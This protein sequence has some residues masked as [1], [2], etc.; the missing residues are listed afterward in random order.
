M[1]LSPEALEQQEKEALQKWAS[2]RY[3]QLAVD[4]SST[5]DDAD[6]ADIATHYPSGDPFSW[7][8]F[9]K[10]IFVTD[11]QHPVDW[12]VKLNDTSNDAVTFK[13]R[14]DT[15]ERVLPIDKLFFT[16]TAT[17]TTDVLILM[18]GY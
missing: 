8:E 17:S 12:E 9:D 5:H 16:N 15:M 13:A 2:S 6:L 14:G 18:E 1:P 10:I 3:A 7:D 4:V 11:L